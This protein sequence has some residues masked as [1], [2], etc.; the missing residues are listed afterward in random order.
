MV[1][2]HR[3]SQRLDF[4]ELLRHQ[5]RR[6]D[7]PNLIAQKVVSPQS[8]SR[9]AGMSDISYD[10]DRP[11]PIRKGLVGGGIALFAQRYFER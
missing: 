3:I 5:G 7:K 4:R 8:A 9:H 6:P 2:R 1:N 11:A 10:R